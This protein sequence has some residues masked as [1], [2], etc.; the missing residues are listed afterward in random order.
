ML[1]SLLRLGF[2]F[3]HRNVFSWRFEFV[4]HDKYII[5]DRR[6]QIN[7]EQSLVSPVVRLLFLGCD[8]DAGVNV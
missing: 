4:N 8:F 7:L 3:K 1:A 5:P 2:G 6:L